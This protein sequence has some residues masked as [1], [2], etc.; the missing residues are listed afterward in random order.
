MNRIEMNRVVIT[1]MG[2]ASPVGHSLKPFWSAL[3]EPRSG[4]RALT[5]VPTERLNTR[6]A[7]QIDDF[8]PAAHF[9][10]KFANQLDRMS[11]FAVYAARAAVQ[12]CGV[13]MS[14]ELALQTATIV[15]NGAGGQNTLDE[16]YYR[17]YGQNATRL[18]PLCVPRLMNNAAGSQVSIDLGLKGPGWTVASACASAGHAIGQ[19]Y[20]LLRGGA[21]AMAV[22]G[23]TEACLSVGT[24]K[25]WE[26][27]RVLTSDT[28]RP[29]SRTRSGIVLGEGAAMFVLERRD[30]AARLGAHIY[31]EVL[32]FGMSTDAADIV[33]ADAGGAARAMA[34]AIAD[35]RLNADDIDYVNAHGTGTVLNDKTESEALRRVFGAHADRLAVSSSKAVLGH[36]LGAAG[37]LELAATAL[38]LENQVVPPTANFQEP[39]PDCALDI[40][41]NVARQTPLRYVMSNS[42][43]FGGLNA[44][45]V[46]GRA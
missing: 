41:P 5:I 29:F 20:H 23:G 36:S 17:L 3:I 22:T 6:I 4:I 33:A 38:A 21:V 16:S 32:G 10:P 43:A 31:A 12:D 46:L 7:A 27:L 9:D 30:D 13:A 2:V 45:L 1:G 39:D 8:D 24:I 19:A 26:G 35:A 14:E 28:C 44:V 42:F 37:A 15:G 34:A 40:V 18:H 25:G 11:Q